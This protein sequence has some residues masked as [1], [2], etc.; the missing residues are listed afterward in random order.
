VSAAAGSTSVLPTATTRQLFQL[1]AA[2]A[3]SLKPMTQ[4][5]SY[6]QSMKR[7][8]TKCDYDAAVHELF[9]RLPPGTLS[10]PPTPQRTHMF[11]MQMSTGASQ[12][13]ITADRWASKAVA[14]SRC[15]LKSITTAARTPRRAAAVSAAP[16]WRLSPSGPSLRE[17]RCASVTSPPANT[18]HSAARSSCATTGS[19]V[20]ALLVK[21]V[22]P[23]ERSQ[24]PQMYRDCH[25]MYFK[26]RNDDV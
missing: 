4:F 8:L 19:S 7:I 23:L 11:P 1:I 10:P 9:S 15:S 17:R 26:S 22:C 13:A 2:N 6:I 18:L 25:N 14:F 12:T 24:H 3:L 5:P 20:C 16:A 21:A